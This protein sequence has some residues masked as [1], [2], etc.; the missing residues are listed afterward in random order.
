MRQRSGS[1]AFE[2]VDRGALA[3]QHAAG[4]IGQ[5]LGVGTGP[6]GLAGTPGRDVHDHAHRHGHHDER[7]ERQGVLPLVDGEPVDRRREEEVEQ[8]RSGDRGE[9]RRVEPAGEGDADHGDEEHQD[10]AGEGQLAAHVGQQQREQG[11]SGD[12]QPEAEVTARPGQPAGPA[13]PPPALAH[14]LVRDHVHVDRPGHRGRG[15]ADAPGEDL[16]EPPAP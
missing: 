7:R 2:Q 5:R 14:L 1:E 15:D 13:R 10:V 3:A 6:R 12:G 8:Q 11:Q 9:Q 16:R 4:Q